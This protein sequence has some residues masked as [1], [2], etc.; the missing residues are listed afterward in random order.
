[1]RRR[2]FT[3]IE[4]TVV[5]LILALLAASIM[6]NVATAIESN[7]RRNF[8]LAVPRMMSDAHNR[9]V[10]SGQPVFM[11]TNTDDGFQ[12]TNTQDGQDD[13]VLQTLDAVDGVTIDSLLAADGSEPSDDWKVGFYPDGTS[14]GGIVE[15]NDSGTTYR[16]QIVKASSR[17][18][19]LGEDDQVEEDKWPAGDLAIR[20]GTGG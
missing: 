18:K 16:Y 9:A 4:L 14:D 8:R 6:P 15:L 12:L 7:R 5:I 17:V 11:S 3:L 10:Q 1:M 13:N 2:A 20:T 19:R